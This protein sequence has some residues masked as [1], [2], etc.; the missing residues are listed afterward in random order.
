MTAVLVLGPSSKARV[1]VRWSLEQAMTL[2]SPSS[3][4]PKN[5]KP[6]PSPTLSTQETQLR[7]SPPRRV[8]LAAQSP[9][10]CERPRA[11]PRT[12]TAQLS[13]AVQHRSVRFY[14]D[15]SA[16]P[17]P[18]EKNGAGVPPPGSHGQARWLLV[19]FGGAFSTTTT[20]VSPQSQDS[21][22]QFRPRL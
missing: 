10:T 12:P 19:E 18:L 20:K 17:H 16:L 6:Q 7:P 1:R 3:W 4:S 8:T 2:V 13:N 22:S 11:P 14:Q 5:T 21:R 9:M 15:Q